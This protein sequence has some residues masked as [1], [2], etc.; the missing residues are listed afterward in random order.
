MSTKL[1]NDWTQKIEFWDRYFRCALKTINLNGKHIVDVPTNCDQQTIK[2]LSIEFA[3]SEDEDDEEFPYSIL[4]HV[5][6]YMSTG[7][8]S[9][10]P[11]LNTIFYIPITT[12]T[13]E[14]FKNN[15]KKLRLKKFTNKVHNKFNLDVKLVET[16]CSVGIQFEFADTYKNETFDFTE[17]GNCVFDYLGLVV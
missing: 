13:F 11:C 5:F 2:G 3:P 9:R 6:G 14:F 7:F 16:W 10:Q 12:E 17:I 1:A 15:Y 8:C 4:F